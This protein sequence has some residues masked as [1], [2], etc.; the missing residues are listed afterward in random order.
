[1]RLHLSRLL[2]IIVIVAASCKKS[3]TEKE[4]SSY[5][6]IPDKNMV[7][8]SQPHPTVDR[9]NTNRIAASF[10]EIALPDA[11]YLASTNKILWNHT[12]GSI[13]NSISDGNLTLSLSPEFKV[14]N[15]DYGP[16]WGSLPYIEYT[17]P[18]ILGNRSNSSTISLSKPVK[19]FGF[20]FTPNSYTLSSTW[21]A[22]FYAGNTI[23]GQV[24]KTFPGSTSGIG[25]A[26]LIAA[27]TDDYFDKVIIEYSSGDAGLGGMLISQL[28]YAEYDPII[29][30]DPITVNLDM[31]PRDCK[32]HLNVKS[33]TVTYAAIYGSSTF[34]VSTI[35]RST[36]KINGVSPIYTSIEDIAAPFAKINICD[37][38]VTARDKKNDLSLR[39]ETQ[40]L[41]ATFPNVA[42]NQTVE[43]TITGKLNN[44]TSFEGKDCIVIKR[45]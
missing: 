17:K 25:V 23:V 44:G 42:H 40:F 32:N 33:T 5:Y 24:T 7:H 31:F 1:M 29:V 45:K 41:A 12:Y 26:G 35:N 16:S 2:I 37:C 21:A 8:Q 4:I 38:A 43:V 27:S 11:N 30:Y 6:F 39:F 15:D 20:E 28:R 36:L 13:I 34:D 18:H 22:S 9:N 3:T 19:V 10:T 14:Y